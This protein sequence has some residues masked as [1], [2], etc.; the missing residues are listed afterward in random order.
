MKRATILSGV[1]LII[2]VIFISSCG[3]NDTKDSKLTPEKRSFLDS[4][5]N[6]AT[7]D[8]TKKT[9]KSDESI[10]TLE[11][12]AKLKTIENMKE[13]YRGEMTATAK[14]AA[15]SKIAE[16]DGYHP[17]AL[18]YKAVSIAESIHAGNHKEVLQEVSAAIPIVIP[19]FVVK[20]TKENL[21][22]DIDGEANEAKTIYPIYLKVAELADNQQAHTSILYAQ[23]TEKK[24]KIFFEKALGD[25]NSNT[26]KTMPS[27]YFVCPV[28]GNTY[29][30][31]APRRC[32][33]SLTPKEKFIK[34]T[35]L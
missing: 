23:E 7:I 26:M 16:K 30:A 17:I 8:E 4:A 19:A 25:I 12:N 13:A 27:V 14:Y 29:E 5:S 9:K 21:H 35:N 31:S 3:N 11:A 2:G 15:Y 28:C 10:D 33:F 1:F 20:S 18:L 32:D 24:H 6:K 22:D 34:I